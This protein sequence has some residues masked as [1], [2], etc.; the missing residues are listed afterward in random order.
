MDQ[1]PLKT[2]KKESVSKDRVERSI[3]SASRNVLLTL[4]NDLSLTKQFTIDLD[5]KA[6]EIYLKLFKKESKESP[7]SKT[8]MATPAMAS[9][10]TMIHEFQQYAVRNINIPFKVHL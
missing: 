9:F 5:R 7:K 1:P 6:N 4:Q 10:L 3:I 8:M 2:D